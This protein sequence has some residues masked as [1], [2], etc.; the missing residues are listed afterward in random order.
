M[1]NAFSSAFAAESAPAAAPTVATTEAQGLPDAVPYELST[2]KMFKDTLVF[3]FLMFSIFYFLLIRPQQK[4][5]KAHAALM[6]DLKKGDR[7]MIGGGILGTLAKFE[8]DDVAVVEIAPNVKVRVARSQILEKVA[9]G[10]ISD[11][12]ND[13]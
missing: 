13:N 1:T 6:S 3:L 11:N 10:T 8:G 12:A 9:A 5:V 2:E 7:V 4:R